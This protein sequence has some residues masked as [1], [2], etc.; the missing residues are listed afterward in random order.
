MMRLRFW[1]LLPLCTVVCSVSTTAFA[2][3]SDPS[4]SPGY[5]FQR[6]GWT[7]VHL[8]GTPAEIGYQHGRLLAD[9]DRGPDR[10]HESRDAALHQTRLGVLPPGRANRALAAHRRRIP[11]GARGHR[12]RRAVARRQA[13]R[14]GHR[15]PERRH[16]AARVLRSRG[17]TSA[18][19][20]RTRRP[21]RR[22]SALKAAARHSSPP[23]ATPKTARSSSRTTTGRAT[24]RV[25]A[26]P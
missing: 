22:R 21:A 18:R 20:P 2:A 5:R 13:R 14:L 8:E 11:P 19:K 23:A 4:A 26:G 17:W 10:C 24:P 3:A 7:Y 15:G 16:R 25:R 1:R 9:R 12:A 6:G